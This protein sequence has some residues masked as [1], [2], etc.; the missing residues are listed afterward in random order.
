[1]S[2]QFLSGVALLSLFL[3]LMA[4]SAVARTPH[5]MTVAIPFAFTIGETTLPAGTYTVDRPNANTVN[6]FSIC[7][8]NHQT[9]MVFNT[10][11]IEADGLSAAMRLE[12]RR[13]GD[14]YFLG[15][16]W[17]GNGNIGHELAQSSLERELAKGSKPAQKGGKIQITPNAGK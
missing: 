7:D 12:F 9:Q 5:Q 10:H 11:T 6:V 14:Q 8:A 17:A 15:Q 4:I 3:V 2:K 13:Y 1:M 16:V